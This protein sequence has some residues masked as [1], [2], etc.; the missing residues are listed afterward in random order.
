MQANR[1]VYDQPGRVGGPNL[2]GN[3]LVTLWGLLIEGCRPAVVGC[4]SPNRQR[5]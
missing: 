4:F 3:N 1:A 5:G 2:I